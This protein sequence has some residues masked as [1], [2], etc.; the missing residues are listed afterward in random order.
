[1]LA[2]REVDAVLVVHAPATFGAVSEQV[3]AIDT[4]ASGAA[5]P[6]V[7]VMLGASDGPL[8]DG[9]MIPNFSFPEQAAA[10]LGRLAAYSAWRRGEAAV[11]PDDPSD[12]PASYIDSA[13]AG[14][15]LASF[16]DG[17]HVPPDRIAELLGAYGVRMPP[18]ELVD[19]GDAVDAARRL[20][21]P[22][23]VKA[24]GRRIGRSVEAGISLDLSDDSDVRVSTV[25]MQQA[26]GSD[27]DRVFVQR[28]VPPGVD[29]RIRASRDARLGPFVSVGI[30]GAQADAIGDV[31]SRLAPIS[32]TTARAMVAGTRAAAMLDDHGL[33]LVADQLTR[34]AQLV[35]D[36]D[37][38]AE[39]DL[40]P[41]I[42]SEGGSWVTDARIELRQPE[43]V[44][45]ALRR[46]E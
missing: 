40:N 4:A 33:D 8:G 46:L 17:D 19:I 45:Q 22:V 24:V 18:T 42:L 34:I 41:V 36:H 30:G 2:D 15:V 16:D 11:Q 6:V 23:A 13:T 3:A 28:M 37:R 7:A 27:A 32:P 44:E 25:A 14:R 29:L 20:G 12:H 39:L 43:R 35:S 38:I 9:S 26:L 21:F 10:V 1:V 31:A 5:K